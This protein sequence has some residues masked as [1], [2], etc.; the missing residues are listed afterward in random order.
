MMTKA[1]VIRG[2][3]HAN[4]EGKPKALAKIASKKL[5]NPVKPS[6]V[7]NYKTQMKKA[8]QLN[9]MA[10]APEAPVAPRP[11][12]VAVA[13]AHVRQTMTVTKTVEVVKELVQQLGKDELK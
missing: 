8:S 7:S 13:V 12:P 6:D 11:A 9:G 5:G 10:P 1:D 3:L 2:L 4:P